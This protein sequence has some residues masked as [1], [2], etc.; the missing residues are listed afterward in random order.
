MKQIEWENILLEKLKPLADEERFK[1]AEY[2]REMYADKLETGVS[3]EEILEE[4]GS[5]QECAQKILQEEG[6]EGESAQTEEKETAAPS[7]ETVAEKPVAQKK[8][9]KWTPAMIMGMTFLT[10]LVI[11]PLTAVALGVIL[12]FAAGCIG[13]GAVVLAGGIYS[14]ASL[15]FGIFGME[16]GGVFASFGLGVAFIGVG[17]LLCVGFYYATKY[18]VIAC[19]KG[20]LWVYKRGE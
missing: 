7:V 15:F 2:Y 1:I 18:T 3:P 16:T 11:L 17:F 13:G 10:L 20:L 6:K 19:C 12:S 5:P 8:K 14:L 4:F 9:Q